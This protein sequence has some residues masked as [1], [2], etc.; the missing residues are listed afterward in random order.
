MRSRSF[1]LFFLMLTIA[2]FGSHAF[3]QA[4]AKEMKAAEERTSKSSA[5]MNEIMRIDDRSIP[6]D[7]LRDA[8]AIVVFPGALKLGF[9]VGGQGGRGVAIRRLRNGWSAPAFLNMGGAS[10][11]PQIGGQKTDYILLIMND[12]GLRRL[13]GDNFEIGGEGSVS[14]GPVGRTAAASTNIRL[15]AEILTYS[16]SKGLFAGISLKGVVISQDESMNKAIYQK[17]AKEVLVD[18]PVAW[19]AA[20]RSLQNFPKT[21]AVYSK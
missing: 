14:A 15:D 12:N 1:V 6:R 13:L 17:T 3:A 7:L 10:I 9:I 20:P 16:R 21:V 18:S 5:V 11:G 2:A 19:T 8:K 4:D